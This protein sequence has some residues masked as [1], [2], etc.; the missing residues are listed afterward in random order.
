MTIC[1]GNLWAMWTQLAGQSTKH[2]G[3]GELEGSAGQEPA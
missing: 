2:H 1:G 3:L